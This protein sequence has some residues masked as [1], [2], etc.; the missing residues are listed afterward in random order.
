MKKIIF[1]L[2]LVLTMATSLVA[3]TLAMYTTSIDNLADGSVVAKEF[4]FVGS[5]T[6]SFQHGIKI[7][8]TET[9]RWQF[10][11]KNYENHII[12]ETD[13]YYKLT[14]NVNASAGKKTIQ[15]LVVNVKDSGGNILN[16]V[17][18]IG[19]FDVIGSFPLSESGQE[20]DYT[21]E[22]YWPG[23]K[24]TDINYAGSNF[25]TTIN[26]DAVASQLPF[27]GSNPGNEN[28]NEES[29]I[30][31]RYETTAPW[32]NGQSGINEFEYKVTITNN[33]DEAI[34]DWE[35]AFSLP[36]DRITRAWSNARMVSGLPEGSYKF[37]NPGYNNV[38][39]DDI[40]P[41]QSVSFRGPAIG[42]GTEAIRNISVGGS[43]MA[44]SSNVDLTYEFGKS[45][46]N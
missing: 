3:G 45:S 10:K 7:A 30:S 44:P 14:F 46:L 33:S 39:T 21:I 6:D 24:N 22:I 31:V 19:T 13:L 42:N 5:G 11:V 18:G 28:P 8:P 29:E 20:R 23:D 34:E 25:G 40:L 9:V 27:D 1:A 4:V 41:G 32:Q 35:I 38:A 17:A 26:V 16:S 36:A 12:T 43:N 2:L 37:I 15:P